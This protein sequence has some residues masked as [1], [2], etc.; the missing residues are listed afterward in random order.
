[1]LRFEPNIL[2]FVASNSVVAKQVLQARFPQNTATIFQADLFR[3]DG[4]GGG[5][6]YRS[7]ITGILFALVEFYLLGETSTVIH[8]R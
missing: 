8:S 4:I 2:F 3:G 7:S 6:G 1:M 5:G